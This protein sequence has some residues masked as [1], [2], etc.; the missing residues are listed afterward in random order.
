MYQMK[1]D[2]LEEEAWVCP[3][4]AGEEGEENNL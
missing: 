4:V 2:L 1:Q 3:E